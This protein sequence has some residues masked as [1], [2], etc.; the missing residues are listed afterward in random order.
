MPRDLAALFIRQLCPSISL[1]KDSRGFDANGRHAFL[2]AWMLSGGWSG[3][4]EDR[5]QGTDSDGVYPDGSWA[6]E[7]F[8]TL[9]QIV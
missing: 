9:R 8:R 1:S 3:D 7:P 2:G 5:R 4:R 6:E